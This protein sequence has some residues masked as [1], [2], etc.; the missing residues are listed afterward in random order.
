IAHF[1]LRP[2]N[3]KPVVYLKPTLTPKNPSIDADATVA[4]GVTVDGAT[5][6]SLAYH[7]TNT[8]TAGHLAEGDD[9]E[10]TSSTMSY[11]A[12]DDAALAHDTIAVD[13][14]DTAHD[15]AVPLVRAKTT[16]AVGCTKCSG[17]G[18]TPTEACCADDLDND[19]DGKTDCDDPDCAADPACG[20]VLS[21]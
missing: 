14:L 6:C 8:A 3:G 5:G 17:A 11:Q 10:T 15:P 7:W 18:C 16:V 13:V 4:L 9:V 12:D 2:P 21:G 19:G 1:V 20:Y